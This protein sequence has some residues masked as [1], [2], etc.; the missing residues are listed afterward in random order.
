MKSSEISTDRAPSDFRV[1]HVYALLS[2]AA[3]AA[4]VWAAR[5]THPLALLLLSGAVMATGGTALWLHHALSAFFSGSQE[6]EPLGARARELLE[7]E[8][9]LTLRSI[10][11]LEFDRA[12]G[13][14]G[15]A[16]F[17]DMTSR[18]RARALSLMQDLERTDARVTVAPK[19]ARARVECSS[20][21][22]GNDADAKFCKNCG[23]RLNE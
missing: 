12:M 9:A 5:N 16:D 18:L 6:A 17:D 22:T 7:R 10:K 8:K 1:W 20:C 3:A 23:Q 13:K 2:V 21:R 11:E 19:L 4:A 14:V 15:D